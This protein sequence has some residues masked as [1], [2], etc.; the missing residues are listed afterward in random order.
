MGCGG[1]FIPGNRR[2]VRGASRRLVDRPL[3]SPAFAGGRNALAGVSGHNRALHAISNHR[4]FLR[5]SAGTARKYS[6]QYGHGSMD[7]LLWPRASRHHPRHR[8]GCDDL[9]GGG[10]PLA[11]G[12]VCRLV[13]DLRFR[14]LRVHCRT[15]SRRRPRL[16]RRPTASSAECLAPARR[17]W[18]SAANPLRFSPRFAI[19]NSVANVHVSQRLTFGADSVYEAVEGSQIRFTGSAIEIFSDPANLQGLENT[20]LIV[21][22]ERMS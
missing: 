17:A 9:R 21:E 15:G 20:Q 18:D 4:P 2:N 22:G 6:A 16:D 10:R 19:L 13:R 14:A 1:D 8:D 7:D 3:P 5:G 12:T 11:D